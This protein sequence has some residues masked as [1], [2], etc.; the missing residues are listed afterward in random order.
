M[1]LQMWYLHYYINGTY[2]VHFVNK[3]QQNAFILLYYLRYQHGI[4]L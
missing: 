3:M 1:N 2:N 4:R